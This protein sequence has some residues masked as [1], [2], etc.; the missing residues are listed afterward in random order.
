MIL[1]LLNDVIAKTDW[2]ITGRAKYIACRILETWQ[3]GRK[4]EADHSEA[5]IIPHLSHVLASD[6]AVHHLRQA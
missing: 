6:Y 1:F 5:T 4:E 2:K 3:N